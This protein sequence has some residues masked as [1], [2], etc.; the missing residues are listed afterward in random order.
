KQ[1]HGGKS[2]DLRDDCSPRCLRIPMP[3][4]ILQK[5]Q[6]D[7]H[8]RIH[9]ITAR[10]CAWHVEA[11]STLDM[12]CAGLANVAREGFPREPTATQLRIAQATHLVVPR[13]CLPVTSPGLPPG[14]IKGH[15]E[16]EV[17]GKRSACARG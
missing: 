8:H 7:F 15:E 11:V 2:R 1:Q 13:G 6:I 16:P 9:A 4:E 12:Y 17:A 10:C 5:N 14:R 3:H